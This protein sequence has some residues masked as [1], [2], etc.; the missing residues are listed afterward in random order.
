MLCRSVLVRLGKWQR[1][2]T[3]SELGIYGVY[4]RAGDSVLANEEVSLVT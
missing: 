1:L 2:P 3:L 4:C